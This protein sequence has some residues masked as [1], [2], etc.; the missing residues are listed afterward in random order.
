VKQKKS[1]WV[2]PKEGKLRR[3]CLIEIA[4]ALESLHYGYKTTQ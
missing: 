4:L 3:D 2:G 1:M